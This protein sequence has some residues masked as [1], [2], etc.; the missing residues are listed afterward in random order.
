MATLLRL[1]LV[2]QIATVVAVLWLAV[3]LTRVETIVSHR[4]PLPAAPPR[5]P[6]GPTSTAAG[7]RRPCPHPEASRVDASVLGRPQFLCLACDTT[8]PRAQE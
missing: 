4:L 6:P 7:Q 3:R 5:R 1:V 2:G 8:V